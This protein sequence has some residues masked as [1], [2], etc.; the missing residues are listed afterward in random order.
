MSL[1]GT[2]SLVGTA[3]GE[4]GNPVEVKWARS[5]GLKSFG[6]ASI[7]LLQDSSAIPSIDPP[8]LMV[9]VQAGGS[10]AF[11]CVRLSGHVISLLCFTNSR[12]LSQFASIAISGYLTRCT[13]TRPDGLG[14]DTWLAS[15][16]GRLVMDPRWADLATELRSQT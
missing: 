4:Q 3:Y 1:W 10:H 7:L 11:R 13:T 9:L 12:F 8:D 2:A 14:R 16:R 15:I 5:S 6:S